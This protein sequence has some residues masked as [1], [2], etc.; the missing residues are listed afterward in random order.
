MKNVLLYCTTSHEILFKLTSVLHV[1]IA[2]GYGLEDEG[3]GVRVTVGARFFN[4]QV[5][6]TG[7]GAHPAS[8]L[9]RTTGFFFVGKSAGA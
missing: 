5:V 9:R 7:S 2:T 6:H 4:S 8:Y 1:S 3:I